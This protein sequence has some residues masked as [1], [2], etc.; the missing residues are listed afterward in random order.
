MNYSN[1]PYGSM[2]N[3]PVMQQ[4]SGQAVALY[5]PHVNEG[6][7]YD[8][9]DLLALWRIVLRYRRMIVLIFVL[10]VAASGA[11][12]MLK[13]PIYNATALLEVNT[14]SRNLVKFQNLESE[15]VSAGE[16]FS[17]QTTI[18]SSQAVASEVIK[19]LDLISDPEI[20]GQLRQRDFRTGLETL[21]G[22]FKGSADQ[23][24]TQ[25]ALMKAATSRYLSRLTI[26]PIRN[27][28]LIRVKFDSFNPE[29][30]TKIVNEHMQAYIWLSSQ[31]RFDSTSGAKQFLENE[32]ASVQQKLEDS[33]KNLTEYA[34][35]NGVIDTEDR[36]NIMLDRLTKLNQNLSA[37]QSSRIDAETKFIQS[38]SID[39]GQ[40]S[41]VIEDGLI[42]SLR[43]EQAQLRAEYNELSKI[44][45]SG[46]PLMEQLQAKI[47]EIESS[48]RVQASNIVSGLRT[49]FEQ[50]KLREEH[51]VG[52]LELLKDE[53]L[54]LQDRAV[55][56]N[57]LKR[58]FEAN[59]QLYVN[60]LDRTKEVGVA[61]GME[62]NVASVVDEA[63]PS[64]DQSLMKSLITASLLGLLG[65]FGV[66][67]LLALLDNKVNDP[68]QLRKITRLNYL[69]VAPTIK[70]PLLTKLKE[71]E[72]FSQNMSED[73]IENEVSLESETSD[74]AIAEE[75]GTYSENG[76]ISE[77]NLDQKEARLQANLFNTVMHHT[78][79]S[80]YAE[81][82]QSLRTSLSFVRADGLP[83]S[84]MVTSATAGEG[85]STLAMNLAIS[86][87]KSGKQVIVIDADL[88]R[89]R[90]SD[91]FE[92][93]ESPGLS[94]HLSDDVQEKLYNIASIEGLSL[95]VSGKSPNNPVD[96]LGSQ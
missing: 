89:S 58:E 71:N 77:Q 22:L 6:I 17:T 10:V 1:S 61:A 69:G 86:F 68:E 76:I 52:E 49:N 20:G 47:D 90:Y 79:N 51:L 60:L 83:K 78:P 42:K 95:M 24:A 50:L 14:G 32:I 94:E 88:R 45:K 41:I 55:A 8:E 18:L 38:Q 75:A 16:H 46:Y 48:V 53:M 82:I 13:R 87:A 91:V 62:L 93:P 73:S 25:D 37:V 54:D 21:M 96:L 43:Q 80:N 11:M 64:S 70:V 19:R 29:L 56:F 7:E 27:S 26:E 5:D 66:A 57:I 28:T 9:I 67:F 4:A 12:T 36:D 15:D 72:E 92:V 59:K 33:Q 35:E 31:R 84:L 85:K 40:L 81:A 2:N 74:D 3:L 65:A 44:Y 23:P 30:S 34:R 63:I 39:Y